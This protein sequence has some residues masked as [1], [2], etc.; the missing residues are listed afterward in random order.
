ME[1]AL[2][3][4][5]LPF[6]RMMMYSAGNMSSQFL[7]WAFNMYIVYYY[8][9]G[10]KKLLPITVVSTALFIGRFIDGPLEP[11][12]GY[13]SDRTRT[14]WGRRIPFVMFGGLPMCIFF[15]LMWYPP[16]QP[17]TFAMG[18][19]LIVTQT[20]F[21][22]CITVVFC[23]YLAL[24]GEVVQTSKERVVIS[25]L[26]Q[27]F[28]LIATGIVMVLPKFFE[29]IRAHR[30]MFAIVAVIGLM[31]I[32]SVVIGVPEKKYCGEH[33]EE[34][35]GIGQALKWTF[36]NKAFLYFVISSIFM[37]LGFQTVM[38]SLMFV[39][40]ILLKM[41]EGYLP[42][43]FGV[44]VVSVAVSFIIIQKMSIKYT[45]KFVYSLG[46]GMMAAVLPLMYVLGE[47]TIFGLPVLPIA[48]VFFFLAGFPI[49][50]LM[51]LGLPILADIADYDAKVYG[52]RREAIFFGAQ[53]IVQKYAI[54][55]TFPIQ[56]FLFNTF[57][58]ELSGNMG[59]RLMGPVTGVFVFVGLIIFLFY[60]LDERK[61]EIV[62]VPAARFTRKLLRRK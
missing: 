45:K 40:T 43:L 4:P 35:Y 42:V 51:C 7:Q 12:V 16:F 36:T 26:M 27:V 47:K 5:K 23:P 55:L 59:L 15:L 10:D 38:S 28:L 25:Q 34:H 30:E 41:P 2:T 33:D 1:N 62:D 9:G 6:W 49:A 58:Y 60:P 21:W 8:C 3:R 11:V 61:M 14:R 50:V 52:K 20:C 24:L 37:L 53:G 44:I 39:I 18:A 54:A 17:N 19:W 13:W 32:Y 31:S 48:Y 29:P 22:L 57:G 46:I 56:G